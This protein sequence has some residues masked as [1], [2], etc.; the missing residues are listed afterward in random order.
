MKTVILLLFVLIFQSLILN[1]QNRDSEFRQSLPGT[2]IIVQD[3]EEIKIN[4]E[5][6]YL[7]NGDYRGKGVVISKADN[8][9]HPIY[10]SG[11]WSI[12]N[13]LLTE[14]IVDSNIPELI[15]EKTCTIV[16]ITSKNFAHQFDDGTIGVSTRKVESEIA[17][18]QSKTSTNNSPVEIT[19]TDIA[20]AQQVI[21]NNTRTLPGFNPGT[22]VR[23]G[24]GPFC[25][26]DALI[27]YMLKFHQYS[28]MCP[29]IAVVV[30]SLKQLN[31]EEFNKKALAIYWQE[32]STYKKFELNS[33]SFLSDYFSLYILTKYTNKLKISNAHLQGYVAADEAW[34]N[35]IQ[36]Q[37]K[38][39]QK[40]TDNENE[41]ILNRE[42]YRV[43][44]NAQAAADAAARAV[45]SGY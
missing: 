22:S 33:A 7:K 14:K 24:P 17:E 12:S 11:K 5:D 37:Q 13:G 32:Y 8:V 25:P 1:G 45:S 26:S 18:T 2:W 39:W 29:P 23:S 10:I 28:K 27:L 9:S 15:G 6:E 4:I 35:A 44:L 42:G 43:T 21:E 19:D 30:E 40:S 16:S 38:S 31:D 3:L 34:S 41:F 36:S 20:M